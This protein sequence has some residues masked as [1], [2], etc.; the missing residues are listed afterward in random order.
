[1]RPGKLFVISSP[2]GGGKTTLGLR[3]LKETPHMVR[4]ISMTTRERRAGERKNRDYFFVTR[5]QFLKIK[6]SKGFLEQAKVFGNLYGTPH[7]FIRRMTSHG[8]DVALLIDVQG[9]KQVRK[10]DQR[11]VLIFIMP[12]SM[13]VLE[14]RLKKR[15]TDSKIEITKRLR[16]AKSEIKQ[17]K[18]YDYVIM[19]K[20]LS[21]ALA[22]LKAIITAER[23]RI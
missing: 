5:P 16:V 2:S 9:A 22:Q 6:R 13:K 20:N 23:L 10:K 8:F 12:H 21:K 14:R 7:S 4:S 19:N 15:Q 1:M 3:L 17:A 18:H 11:A